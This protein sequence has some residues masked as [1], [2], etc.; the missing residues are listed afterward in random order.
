MVNACHKLCSIIVLRHTPSLTWSLFAPTH[1]KQKAHILSCLIYC[2]RLKRHAICLARLF[3]HHALTVTQF[4]SKNVSPYNR[5]Q[6]QPFYVF[7]V[8]KSVKWLIYLK[9]EKHTVPSWYDSI[10]VRNK[11]ESIT[12]IKNFDGADSREERPFWALS[13]RRV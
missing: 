2:F 11:L 12:W 13:L 9:A 7:H 10:P 5:P 8:W 6:K 3:Y 1:T 4:H